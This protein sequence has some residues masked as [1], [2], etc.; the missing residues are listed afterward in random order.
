MASFQVV[1]LDETSAKVY[2]S[3]QLD[4]LSD[5]KRVDMPAPQQD[6]SLDL[7]KIKQ[8][9]SFLVAWILDLKK[10]WTK[11]GFELSLLNLSTDFKA[12]CQLY[13][14]HTLMLTKKT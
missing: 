8:P 2:G 12:L 6:F 5:L 13:D 7:A 9:S 14:L 3:L 4:N 10:Q 11:Q 1:V